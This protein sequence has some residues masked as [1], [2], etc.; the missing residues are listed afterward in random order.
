MRSV[1]ANL[2]A[3]DYFIWFYHFSNGAVLAKA[4]IDSED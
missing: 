2:Q 1:G 3:T 4:D